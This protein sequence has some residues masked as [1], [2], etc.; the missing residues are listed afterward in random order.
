M[1]FISGI[2]FVGGGVS[3]I[4]FND[5]NNKEKEI[6]SFGDIQIK[7]FNKIKTINKKTRKEE[8]IAII[9]ICLGYESLLLSEDKDIKFLKV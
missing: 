6:T 5:D 7:L 8:P 3:V 2:V 4:N 1:E 9:A